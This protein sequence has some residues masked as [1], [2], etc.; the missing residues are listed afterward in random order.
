MKEACDW[1]ALKPDIVLVTVIK[2]SLHFTQLSQVRQGE[3]AWK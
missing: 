1:D 2:L 3:E